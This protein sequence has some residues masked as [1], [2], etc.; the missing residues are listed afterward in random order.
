MTALAYAHL[1]VC[2]FAVA[3]LEFAQLTV[4]AFIC[5]WSSSVAWP[6]SMTFLVVA[7]LTVTVLIYVWRQWC[8]LLH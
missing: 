1:C 5:V 4:T 6:S 8:S 7:W 2:L 3:F